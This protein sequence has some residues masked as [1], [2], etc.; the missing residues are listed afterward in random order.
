M[1]QSSN[2]IFFLNNLYLQTVQEAENLLGPDELE[3]LLQFG[4]YSVGF[5]QLHN[6]KK[7]IP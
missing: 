1:A 3:D 6:K 4:C 5:D 2:S 7:I